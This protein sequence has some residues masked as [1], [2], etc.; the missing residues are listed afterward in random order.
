MEV[1]MSSYVSS[2]KDVA[3]TVQS[4]I[5]VVKKEFPLDA[6]SILPQMLQV[7]IKVD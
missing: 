3:A 4:I 7:V 2:E 6:A 5:D 1:I